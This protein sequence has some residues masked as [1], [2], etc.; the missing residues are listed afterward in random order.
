MM[1]GMDSLTLDLLSAA[2]SLDDGAAQT[3]GDFTVT[4]LRDAADALTLPEQS[5]SRAPADMNQQ[6]R[7]AAGR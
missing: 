4:E 7:A 1:D 2:A 3:L 6:I 5:R